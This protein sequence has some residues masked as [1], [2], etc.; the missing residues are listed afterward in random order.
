MQ[1]PEKIV[2]GEQPYSDILPQTDEGPSQS[3]S[4]LRQEKRKK[5]AKKGGKKHDRAKRSPKVRLGHIQTDID[6]VQKETQTL[7]DRAADSTEKEQW[8]QAGTDATG[9]LKDIKEYLTR[10]IEAKK[11]V[12]AAR[13][14]Y[15]HAIDVGEETAELA[16][17][18]KTAY[19]DQATIQADLALVDLKYE[20]IMRRVTKALNAD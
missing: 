17:K 1:T 3:Y 20:G 7:A 8:L 12:K 2:N 15:A 18:L 4:E 5:H 16:E 19:A 9:Y 13:K 6:A 11:A 14:T 10:S